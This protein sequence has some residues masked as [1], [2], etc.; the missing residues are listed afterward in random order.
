MSLRQIFQELYAAAEL[1]AI[2]SQ[3]GEAA[4]ELAGGASITVRQQER[5]RQV[6]LS[7][8]GAP[9]SLVEEATFCRDGQIPP[10]AARAEHQ[11]GG[12]CR[13]S[14]T[15][16]LPAATQQPFAFPEAELPL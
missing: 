2:G 9:V 12:L 16:E 7:R 4:R 6:I 3:R 15:W 14:F 13:V 8:Q 10:D 11:R 5:R 1:R